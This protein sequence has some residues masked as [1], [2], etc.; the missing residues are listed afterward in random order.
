MF[1][2]EE[3]QC[4][5]GQTGSVLE[6]ERHCLSEKAACLSLRSYLVEAPFKSTVFHDSRNQ[7]DGSTPV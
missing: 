7:R 5:R 1:F 4:F 2:R 3:G 6:N